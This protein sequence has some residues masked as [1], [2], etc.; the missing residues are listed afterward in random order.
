M[1]TATGDSI[2]R[3]VS[4]LAVLSIALA[5]AAC[6]GPELAPP[7]AFAAVGGG[8]GYDYR[9]ATP[10]GIVVAVRHE[11]NDPQADVGFWANAVDL[12]LKRDGYTPSGESKVKTD[13]GLE[14]VELSYARTDQG[15]TYRYVVALFVKE[16]REMLVFKKHDLFVVEA[17]GD[18]EDFDPARA[19]VERAI[20]SLAD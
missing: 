10:Q 6:T 18:A 1:T 7:P 12:R 15:R 9:A 11:K 4:S 13:R 20:R 8:A 5:S 14:G 17:G 16:R 3:L 19:D 2:M